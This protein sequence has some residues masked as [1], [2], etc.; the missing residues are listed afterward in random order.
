MVVVY[1]TP[2]EKPIRELREYAASHETCYTAWD[3]N[4]YNRR[5]GRVALAGALWTLSTSDGFA[6]QPASLALDPS[7]D[8]G[9]FAADS[10]GSFCLSIKHGELKP[11]REIALIWVPVEGERHKPEMRRGK[12]IAKLPVPCDAASAQSDDSSY[13][14]EAG[15]VDS[16]SIYIA[17]A[18]QPSNVR[19]ASGEVSARMGNQQLNFRSCTSTEGLHFSAWSMTRPNKLPVWRRYLYLGYDVEPT[20]VERDFEE[21]NP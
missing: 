6:A 14:L 10:Q 13:R 9:L 12:I 3:L 7:R 15:R 20:C 8:F 19:I 1:L 18:A 17:V 4:A 21:G 2:R 5:I 11:G 16:E